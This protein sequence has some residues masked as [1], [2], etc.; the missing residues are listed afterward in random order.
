[1]PPLWLRPVPLPGKVGL[2]FR[3]FEMVN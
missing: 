1:M 2:S 3:L